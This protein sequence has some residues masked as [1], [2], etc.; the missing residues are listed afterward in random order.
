MTD[1][2]NFG[3]RELDRLNAAASATTPDLGELFR[4]TLNKIRSGAQKS[5]MTTSISA[6][7]SARMPEKYLAILEAAAN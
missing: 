5:E 4:E 2:L 6:A 3:R 1:T 7:R